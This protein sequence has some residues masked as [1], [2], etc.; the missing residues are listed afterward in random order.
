MSYVP[1]LAK[2]VNV[3]NV[4]VTRQVKQRTE[5]A[6]FRIGSALH[7]WFNKVDGNAT[8]LLSTFFDLLYY[9]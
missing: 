2:A 1:R 7:S 4:L 3:L 6:R 9:V 8:L 5:T